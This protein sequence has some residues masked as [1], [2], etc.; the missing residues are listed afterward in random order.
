MQVLVAED[1]LGKG[2]SGIMWLPF[3]VAVL[4]CA[5]LLY[6]PGYL[7]SH[8]LGFGR[9]FSLAVAPAISAGLVAT[10]CVVLSKANIFAT[11]SSI[12]VPVVAL[13]IGVYAVGH[14]KR[15]A[16]GI[17]PSDSNCERN[18]ASLDGPSMFSVI[19]YVVAS[20]II[21]TVSFD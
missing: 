1:G 14:L 7:F 17:R 2:V 9:F 8:G 19:A 13:C 6:V 5:S 15:R 16:R 11:P 10:W 3:F 18:G 12:L 4:Y 20:A 21:V